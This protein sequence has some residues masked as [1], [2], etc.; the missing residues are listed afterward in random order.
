MNTP[1]I[2]AWFARLCDEAAEL[3]GRIQKLK[4]FLKSEAG[5][6]EQ[7]INDDEHRDLHAQLAAMLVY[8]EI[9]MRRI[10]RNT[11]MQFMGH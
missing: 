3:T 6:S 8:E 2:P 9:L 5:P 11:P 7:R 10:G 4:A 1:A